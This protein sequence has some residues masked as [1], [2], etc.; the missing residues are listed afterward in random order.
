MQS[1]PPPLTTGESR[2]LRGLPASD[3]TELSVLSESTGVFVIGSLT[4]GRAP[5]GKVPNSGTPGVHVK[6]RV[7]T[8]APCRLSLKSVDNGLPLPRL[9]KSL[10]SSVDSDNLAL[11][12]SIFFKMATTSGYVTRP[13]T[14][15]MKFSSRSVDP[16]SLS[17]KD[18]KF[19][20]NIGE[21]HI[22]WTRLTTYV[23]IYR[24]PP[25]TSLYNIDSILVIVIDNGGQR[26][27]SRQ[28]GPR[29]KTFCLAPAREN[30]ATNRSTTLD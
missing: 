10:P 6:M 26:A 4:F 23:G 13:A 14:R 20:S 2:L 3:K 25:Y 15:R 27:K 29:Y 24:E 7:W 17:Q 19:E 5:G 28:T 9:P 12:F 30:Q 8:S 16:P 21:R 22:S 18:G 11:A 1:V